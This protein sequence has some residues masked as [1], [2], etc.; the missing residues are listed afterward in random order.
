[1]AAYGSNGYICNLHESSLLHKHCF[2]TL[3]P[4]SLLSFLLST[5]PWLHTV[6]LSWVGFPPS[7]VT[8]PGELPGRA[9]PLQRLLRPLRMQ[10]PTLR[11]HSLLLVP[12]P[13][14]QPIPSTQHLHGKV[15]VFYAKMLLNYLYLASPM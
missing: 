14:T 4:P 3:P 5:L 11:T 13:T 2:L 15:V 7:L 6:N 12:F 1:M 9:G 8:P 10:S